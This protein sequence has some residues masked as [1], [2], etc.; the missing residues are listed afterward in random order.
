MCKNEKLGKT[1]KEL[2][3]TEFWMTFSFRQLLVWGKVRDFKVD[4]ELEGAVGMPL[5]LIAFAMALMGG[6]AG[7]LPGPGTGTPRVGG[8]KAY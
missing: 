3:G 1:T 6:L 8:E 2:M 5:N 7:S 4:L